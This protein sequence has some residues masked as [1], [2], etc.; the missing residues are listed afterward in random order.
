MSAGYIK[1]CNN[2]FAE[3]K[4]VVDKFHVM[5]YVYNAV[6]DVQ[7]RTKKELLSQ[8]S[9]G[10]IKNEQ[11]KKILSKLD[12]LKH[13]RHKLTQSANKWNQTSQDI[14]NKVFENH[15]ELKIAYYL[16]Q[17]FK[18]WYHINNLLNQKAKNINELYKWYLA[19]KNSNIQEFISV[20][21]LIRKHENEIMN[22]FICAH[23]NAKAER[24]NGN[25]NRFI[26]NNYGIRDKDFALYRIAQYFS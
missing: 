22:Y 8:L 16:A 17:S 15:D 18:Q 9:K 20:V 14:I 23:T 10:R 12:L 6:M 24:I 21:K 5:Q 3:A 13:C 25:I 2:Q 11:D 4:I 19:V 26:S 1:V 7:S